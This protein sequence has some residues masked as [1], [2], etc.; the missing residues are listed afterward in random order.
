MVFRRYFRFPRYFQLVAFIRM[1]R[2]LERPSAIY[3]PTSSSLSFSHPWSPSPLCLLPLVLSYS[4]G[5]LASRL[6]CTLFTIHRNLLIASFLDGGKGRAVSFLVEEISGLD[7]AIDFHAS[8]VSVFLSLS[9]TVPSFVA[10][11]EIANNLNWIFRVS[12]G[13][14][15]FNRISI[16]LLIRH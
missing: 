7:H 9:P 11:I 12:I 14:L 15:Q 6:V 13:T 1:S 2:R 8:P 16:L 10:S 4:D 3:R 5:F